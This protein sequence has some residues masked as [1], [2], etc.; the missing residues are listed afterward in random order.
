[1]L[2]RLNIFNHTNLAEPGG[3]VTTAQ[4]GR[5]SGT[6]TDARDVQLALRLQF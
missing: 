6:S 4:F 1:L 2:R 3:T 5:I